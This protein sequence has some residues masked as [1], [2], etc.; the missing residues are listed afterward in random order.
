MLLAGSVLKKS[1]DVVKS[2]AGNF[3]F[4][5]DSN[6]DFLTVF[7]SYGA[8]DPSLLNATVYV[9]TDAARTNMVD[10]RSLTIGSDSSLSVSPSRYFKITFT[11]SSTT[12]TGGLLFEIFGAKY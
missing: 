4:E 8:V 3:V 2:G 10:L 1:V 9:Y 7:T 5:S 12:T 11:N 6:V